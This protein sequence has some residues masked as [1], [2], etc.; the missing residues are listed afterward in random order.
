MQAVIRAWLRGPWAKPV[1]GAVLLAPLAYLV[2]AAFMNALG[3]NPAEALI[4]AT[5]ELALRSLCV[6]LAVTPVRVMS[7]WPEWARLRR[8][9]GLIAFTYAVLHVLSYS[10]FDMGFDWADIAT[11]LGKRPFIFVGMLTFVVLLALAATSFNAAIRRL[12]ARRWQ[13][14][15]RLV[16]ASALLA[17]LHFYW[18]RSGK[19]NFDDVWVYGGI[20]ALLL[21]WRLWR[22]LR[23]HK[24]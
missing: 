7:G 10:W 6:A 22:R 16:Y 1:V 21:G 5:G 8:M 19:H 2:G 3:P 17:L 14:L 9:I 15:H 23:P 18:K 11:D 24:N 4:L 20:I 12:G 13:A